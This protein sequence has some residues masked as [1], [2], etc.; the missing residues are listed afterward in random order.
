MLEPESYRRV[1]RN[2]YRLHCQFVSG[3]QR[4]AA[5]DYFMLVCGP[6]SAEQQAR[7]PE[8]AA[9]EIGDNGRLLHAAPPSA[10]P[11]RTHVTLGG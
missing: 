7:S 6:L 4:R 2:L 9:S 1:R 3:N 11:G 5:Y 10:D 8:G